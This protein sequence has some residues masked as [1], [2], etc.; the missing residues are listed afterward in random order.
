MHPFRFS[1]AMK[2]ASN[3]D[4]DL[5]HI[6]GDSAVDADLCLTSKYTWLMLTAGIPVI[7]G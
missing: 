7:C 2:T 6:E 1:F 4:T 3:A 5:C